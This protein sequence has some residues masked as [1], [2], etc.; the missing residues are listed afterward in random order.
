MLL[1]QLQVGRWRVAAAPVRREEQIRQH[2]EILINGK[3]PGETSLIVWQQGGNRLF[4]DLTVQRRIAI[5]QQRA[6]TLRW[7]V[8]NVFN[9][10]NFGLPSRNIP[11]I[12]ARDAT[13]GTISSLSG[14]PRIMQVAV[15][16]TF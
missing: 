11:N 9:R 2:T 4:F 3:T 7:D 8:F 15:R 6:L 12:G 14:D 5:A 16:V 1:Q 10:V 13:F